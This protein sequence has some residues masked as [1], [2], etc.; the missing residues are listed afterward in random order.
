MKTKR[1]TFFFICY[2]LNHRTEDIWIDFRPIQISDMNKVGPSN[3]AE[4]RYIRIA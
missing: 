3:L 1:A 4:T 2:S